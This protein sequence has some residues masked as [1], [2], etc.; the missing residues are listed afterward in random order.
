[1]SAP[2]YSSA[3]YLTLTAA[4]L[5]L[6][7][8]E[9]GDTGAAGAAGTNGL[10]AY[11]TTSGAYTQPAASA[12]VTVSV[13]STAWMSV[14][15]VLYIAGGGYYS[16]TNIPSSMSVL[17]TNLGYSGNAAAGTSISSGA[18]VTPAGMRGATGADGAGAAAVYYSATDPNAVITA[19]RPAVCYTGDG[20]TYVKTDS[21]SSNTGWTLISSVPTYFGTTASRDA[22]TPPSS[23]AVWFLTDSDPAN[24]FSIWNGIVW[25]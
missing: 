13:A 15:L 2:L 3:S 19:T 16:V 7:K 17:L 8:G 14:G 22:F 12:T 1:M 20:K 18:L 6:V 5:T 23:F 9:K 21:G 25:A 4:G 10:N 11:T 24:Q